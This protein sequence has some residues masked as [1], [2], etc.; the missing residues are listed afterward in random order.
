MPENEQLASAE[1][2]GSAHEGK[3]KTHQFA[4]LSLSAYF[5][6]SIRFP[7]IGKTGLHCI[8][9]CHSLNLERRVDSASKSC[10]KHFSFSV[11]ED[12]HVL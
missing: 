7:G 9:V 2:T 5:T 11:S 8:H 3:S 1:Q 12:Y 4:S 6:Y 10:C